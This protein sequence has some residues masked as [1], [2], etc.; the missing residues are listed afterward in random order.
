MRKASTE[1]EKGGEEGV[2]ENEIAR[3]E[4]AEEQSRASNQRK[5]IATNADRC[6]QAV[7]VEAV[8]DIVQPSVCAECES[9]PATVV[10]IW[11]SHRIRAQ[12]LGANYAPAKGVHETCHPSPR[13]SKQDESIRRKKGKDDG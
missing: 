9:C 1:Q 12:P 3:M 5:N 7:V 2:R 10:A 13:K 11:R 6:A 8:C 4:S